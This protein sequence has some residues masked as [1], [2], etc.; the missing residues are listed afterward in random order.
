MLGFLG[1]VKVAKSRYYYASWTPAGNL[2]CRQ[3]KFVTAAIG[4]HNVP[5]GMTVALL[6]VPVSN[7]GKFQGAVARYCTKYDVYSVVRRILGHFFKSSAAGDLLQFPPWAMPLIRWF[8]LDISGTGLYVRRHISAA[9]AHRHWGSRRS[10]DL[11]GTLPEKV[12]FSLS[13]PE[14]VLQVFAELIPD[15]LQDL[16]PSVTGHIVTLSVASMVGLQLMLENSLE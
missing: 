14:Y 15:A 16:S 13:P 2:M 4:V 12:L 11:H 8:C 5:E 3:G 10:N 1:R 7:S 6:M 9:V